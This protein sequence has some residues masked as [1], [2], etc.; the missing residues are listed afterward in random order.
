MSEEKAKRVTP[1]YNHWGLYVNKTG[2]G[3][4][5]AIDIGR[6]TD[7]KQTFY[8]GGLAVLAVLEKR[9]VDLTKVDDVMMEMVQFAKSQS[10]LTNEEKN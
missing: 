10:E 9:G 5:A 3:A 4:T 6:F 7:I 2:I 1:F 8:A